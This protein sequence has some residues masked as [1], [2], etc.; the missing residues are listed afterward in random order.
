MFYMVPQRSPLG[1]EP[2]SPAVV[3]CL[4]IPPLLVFPIYPSC[5]S[6]FLTLASW[7]TPSKYTTCIQVPCHFH[8]SSCFGR[9]QFS[10]FQYITMISI[11]NKDINRVLLFYRGWSNLFL[12]QEFP[13]KTIGQLQE[14]KKG[15]KFKFVNK[16][17]Q[18]LYFYLLIFL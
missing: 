5:F 8:P 2:Q 14:P 9:T 7:E 17:L 15:R 4:I 12:G 3:N 16:I 18:F 11:D 10:Y 6:L 13:G 1:F